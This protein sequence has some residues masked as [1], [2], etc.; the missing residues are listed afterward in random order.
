MKLSL[1]NKLTFLPAIK[2]LFKELNVPMN[3]VADEPTTAQEILKDTYKENATFKLINDVYFV[4]MVDDAAF[5]GNKSLAAEQIK[6]DYDG[7]LVFGITLQ[8]FC[9]WQLNEVLLNK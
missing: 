4:G 8:L 1:F 5:S 2:A 7:I 6:S 3:Y 9:A